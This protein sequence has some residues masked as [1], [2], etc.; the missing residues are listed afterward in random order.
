MDPTL[1]AIDVTIP[2]KTGAVRTLFVSGTPDGI[3]VTADDGSSNPP[4]VLINSNV[5]LPLENFDDVLTQGPSAVTRPAEA[6]P[7]GFTEMIH[8]RALQLADGGRP[9]A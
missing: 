3:V 5:D 7:I 4:Q 6:M 2:P 1:T 8:Q 9:L